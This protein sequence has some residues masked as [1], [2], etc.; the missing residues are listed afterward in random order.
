MLYW[1]AGSVHMECSDTYMYIYIYTYMYMYI[2]IYA[3]TCKGCMYK[4]CTCSSW[5]SSCIVHV[6]GRLWISLDSTQGSDFFSEK[7]ADLGELS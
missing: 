2:Y 4:S 1:W 7:R 3:H 6:G 5:K